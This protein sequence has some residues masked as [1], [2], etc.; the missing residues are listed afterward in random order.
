MYDVIIRNGT[1]VDGTGRPRFRG[2]IAISDGVLVQVGGIVEG[3]AAEVIDADG[4]IVTPGFVDVHTHYDGQVTFDEVLEPSVSHGVT[5]VVTG[6]CGL[7]FAPARPDDH[8]R[9][10]ETME[11]VEDIPGAVLR[12]GLPWEWESF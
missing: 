8:D 10:V 1:V 9:L 3:E 4:L 2:D 5:T 12:A 11:C 7:G 6:S